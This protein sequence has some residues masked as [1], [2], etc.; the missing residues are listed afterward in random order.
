MRNTYATHI[1]YSFL[2]YV[3]ES[4]PLFMPSNL[5]GIIERKGKFLV[6]EWKRPNEKS[7]KGQIRLLCAL[8]ENPK[9]EVLLIKGHTDNGIP[10]IGWFYYV[11]P[12][13]KPKC[14]KIGF[15]TESLKQF[16]KTWYERSNNEQ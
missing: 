7:N 16:I 9:F 10:E 8:A 11:V 12:Y 15:G 14:R 3:I 4:N 13:L 1:D 2:H 5:D 6:M